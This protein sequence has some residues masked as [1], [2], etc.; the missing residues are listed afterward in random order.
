MWRFAVVDALSQ[1]LYRSFV[2]TT[3]RDRHIY[4][5]TMLSLLL[6][7]L[8]VEKYLSIGSLSI[9]RR[10]IVNEQRNNLPRSMRAHD[11]ALSTV[12]LP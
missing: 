4:D 8:V 12:I 3:I 11:R 2:H 1:I 5:V 7:I 6:N 10:R 9:L